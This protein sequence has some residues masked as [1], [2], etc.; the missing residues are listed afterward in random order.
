MFRTRF[1]MPGTAPAALLPLPKGGSI[2]TTIKLVEYD[3]YLFIVIGHS[4]P[5]L[6]RLGDNIESLE[7]DVLGGAVSSHSPR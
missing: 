5:V 4:F 6:K 2:A 3:K 1:P 7:G